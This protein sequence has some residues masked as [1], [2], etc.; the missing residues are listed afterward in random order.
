MQVDLYSDIYTTFCKITR[1]VQQSFFFWFGPMFWLHVKTPEEIKIILNAEESFEKTDHGLNLFLEHGLLTDGGEKYRLQRRTIVPFLAISNLKKFVPFINKK[2]SEF[3]VKFDVKV[4]NEQFDLTPDTLKFSLSATLRTTLNIDHVADE[5]ISEISKAF[6]MIGHLSSIRMFKF[7]L[8][9]DFIF[10]RSKYYNEWLKHRKTGF[11]FV[12]SVIEE[13]EKNYQCGCKQIK[14]ETIVDVLY[15]I[16]HTMT[17][18]EML[19][20]VYLLIGAGFD[21]TGTAIPQ[22]LLL[23][24][25]MNPEHQENC[26]QEI[27][28][29]LTS[30]DDDVTEEKFYQLKY[31]ER[32]IKEGMRLIS[33]ALILSRKV[34]KD[35]K[36]GKNTC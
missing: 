8:A 15:Q 4:Q 31:L 16:R 34:T 29:V 19:Q 9:F 6:R 36:L 32:C 24:L 3:I 7:W 26:Y 23:L 5:K 35:L 14:K 20:S 33:P 30:P 2:M 25:A 13:N 21:T 1:S 28:S 17:Y 12:E 18:D 27:S 10:K 22:T 11:G